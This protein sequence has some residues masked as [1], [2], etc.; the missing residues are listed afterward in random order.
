MSSR[1]EFIEVMM[2]VITLFLLHL[3]V[4]TV[5]AI[6]VG[7]IQNATLIATNGTSIFMNGSCSEC[8]CVMLN[9]TRSIL[10]LN[11][12][13]NTHSCY[14]F[15]NYSQTFIYEMIAEPETIFYFVVSPPES[16]T[17]LSWS[18]DGSINEDNNQMDATSNSNVSFISPGVYGRGSAIFFNGSQY[19]NMS[20]PYL[21]L[22]SN[23]FTF[24]TWIYPL[25]LKNSSSDGC[26][27]FGQCEVRSTSNCM[28]T[29]IRSFNSI[30]SFYNG[31]CNG[32][33]ILTNKTW[34]HLA[35]V[36]NATAQL[37]VIFVNGALDG[38]RTSSPL[39]ITN[40]LT[41]LTIGVDLFASGGSPRY[42]HG[43]IDQLSY[44]SRL[45]SVN[46]I[47]DDANLIAYFSFNQNSFLDS[48]PNQM[49]G[50]AYQLILVDDALLF[51]QTSSAFQIETFDSS[52]ISD[53][54][55]SIA[56]WINPS[57][58][59]NRTVVHVLFNNPTN[60]SFC[61]NMI[62]FD[63]QGHLIS[64]TYVNRT[65]VSITGTTVQTNVWT[66]I[67]QTYSLINGFKLYINGTFI[68]G[69]GS[70]IFVNTNQPQTVTIGNCLQ[71]CQ[72]CDNNFVIN[73]PYVGLID[74]F[75]IYSTELTSSE[76]QTIIYR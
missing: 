13:K 59:N 12:Y 75:R 61:W 5:Q 16:I 67:T 6:Q 9:S 22:S 64:Q 51:N 49:N 24:E 15:F 30:F 48:G 69:T 76:I 53:S 3:I 7:Y 57:S 8:L 47:F 42:F 20:S 70:I 27:I 50:T 38:N 18:F 32:Q 72:I 25:S 44:V 31:N 11:C 17:N 33:L 10:S 63:Y 23:N 29:E 39:Q 28:H 2:I 43:Y 68:N 60:L 19:L 56:F 21:K 74:E 55:T 34:Y 14:L 62:S 52:G 35:F 54:S 36:Y 26:G 58:T 66:H 40:N 1:F 46:E 37:R 71:N 41:P 73:P 65:T 4:N 45:K